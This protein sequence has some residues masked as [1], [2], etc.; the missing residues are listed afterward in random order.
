M[1]AL[2]LS[3]ESRTTAGILLI[4][5][6]VVEYGGVTVLRIVRGSR[7]ALPADVVRRSSAERRPVKRVRLGGLVRMP[8]DRRVR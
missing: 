3:Q 8:L 2:T 5:I 4:A 7:P 6:L 1:L